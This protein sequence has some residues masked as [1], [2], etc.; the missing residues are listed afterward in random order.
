MLGDPAGER[1]RPF[2]L[3][4]GTRAAVSSDLGV[5]LAGCGSAGPEAGRPAAASQPPSR[6]CV[7]HWNAPANGENR[8]RLVQ[9]DYRVGA[10]SS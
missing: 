2:L 7:T 9:A 1:L 8:A 10:A 5:L 6:D 4:D 3:R